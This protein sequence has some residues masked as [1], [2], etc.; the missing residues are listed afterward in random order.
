MKTSIK[1]WASVAIQLSELLDDSG[2]ETV[3]PVALHLNPSAQI[4]FPR[5]S[6]TVEI[7]YINLKGSPFTATWSN[8][9]GQ[10]KT[11]LVGANQPQGRIL[12]HT[13]S[14]QAGLDHINLFSD[15]YYY[16]SLC[17]KNEN[18]SAPVRR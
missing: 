16:V 4:T 6:P 8:G 9:T 15:E 5:S 11:E 17:L 7:R 18:K 13:I 3:G 2:K 12:T 14:D 1:D 10:F